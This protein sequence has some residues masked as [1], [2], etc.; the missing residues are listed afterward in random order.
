MPRQYPPFW[1]IKTNTANNFFRQ[2]YADIEEEMEEYVCM[3]NYQKENYTYIKKYPARISPGLIYKAL[4]FC[5]FFIMILLANGVWESEAT[6]I[7]Y[8]SENSFLQQFSGAGTGENILSVLKQRIPYWLVF[9]IFSQTMP[10][11]VYAGFFAA[12]QGLSIGFVF[13]AMIARYGLRGILVFGGMC[14][15][16]ILIYFLCYFFLY[17][18]MLLYRKRKK[19]RQLQR[20]ESMTPGQK[21]IYIVFCMILTGIFASGIFVECYVNPF[22]LEKVVR[23]L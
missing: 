18:I 8:L 19:E 3:E 15:P 4:F 6:W 1:P 16:Q 11:L 9:V 22:F 23:I 10:G 13:S 12:W 14:F 7:G 20:G 21:G 17:R 5:S 2:A